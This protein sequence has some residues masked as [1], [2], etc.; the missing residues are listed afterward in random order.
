MRNENTCTALAVLDTIARLGASIRY[1]PD[2]DR[3]AAAGAAAYVQLMD[4]LPLRGRKILTEASPLPCVA[5]L[6]AYLA[7]GEVFDFA[8]GIACMLH[9]PGGLPLFLSRPEEDDEDEVDFT[10][11][12]I[13]WGVILNRADFDDIEQLIDEARGEMYFTDIAE[14]RPTAITEAPVTVDGWG[15]QPCLNPDE[16]N[17]PFEWVYPNLFDVNPGCMLSS[18]C[19]NWLRRFGFDET[20]DN[21]AAAKPEDGVDNEDWE[22]ACEEAVKDNFNEAREQW[23]QE[24]E[25]VMHLYYEVPGLASPE[26]AATKLIDSPVGLVYLPRKDT[27]ALILTGG[28]MDLRD[29]VINA[30]VTLGYCPPTHFCLPNLT[31]TKLDCRMRTL[32]AA[33]RRSLQIHRRCLQNTDAELL[34]LAQWVAAQSMKD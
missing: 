12:A 30:Y 28:G 10:N 15:W 20:A 7:D 24:N 2:L 22:F 3:L 9:K 11:A 14:L 19:I 8:A 34:R 27:Y 26:I 32:I 6:Q 25:P 21:L 23:E 4:E 29:K 33:C 1:Q 31:G 18:D 17:E 16:H 13:A 5:T